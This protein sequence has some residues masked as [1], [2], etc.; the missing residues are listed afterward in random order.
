MINAVAEL[1]ERGKVVTSR[2]LAEA[3]HVSQSTACSWLRQRETGTLEAEAMD[4]LLAER[5]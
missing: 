4:A 5:F 3:A 1:E 2:S